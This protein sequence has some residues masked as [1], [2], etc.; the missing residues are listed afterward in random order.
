MHSV[1]PRSFDPATLVRTLLT[2]VAALFSEVRWP[3][4]LLDMEADGKFEAYGIGDGSQNVVMW[5][6]DFAVRH[7]TPA[8]SMRFLGFDK[9]RRSYVCPN[10]LNQAN[11]DWQ[12]TWPKLAQFQTKVLGDCLLHCVVCDTSVKVERLVCANVECDADVLFEGVCM[13]CLG[14]QN[15]PSN[16]RSELSDNNLTF[17]HEYRFEFKRPGNIESVTERILNDENAREH[18]RLSMLSPHLL[19]WQSVTVLQDWTIRQPREGSP[20][21]L[22]RWVRADSALQWMTGADP[23]NLDLAGNS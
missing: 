4:R 18:G 11:R 20:R 10:C 23:S 7:L 21:V 13:T 1:S 15:S 22:G 6:V 17:E 2:A 9:K 12:E 16:F 5:Q 3:Q 8:E 14:E 19:S